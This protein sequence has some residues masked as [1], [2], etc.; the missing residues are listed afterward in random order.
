M[1]AVSVIVP[2]FKGSRFISETI[3]SI[4]NQTVAPLE[5]IIV[6]DC[7]PDPMQYFDALESSI[8]KVIRTKTNGGVCAARNV[9]INYSNGSIIAFSD[10]DDVWHPTKL[11]RQLDLFRAHPSIDFVF[12]NFDY[13]FGEERSTL[14]KFSEAPEGYWRRIAV[15]T[16]DDWIELNHPAILQFLEFQPV[17]PSTVAIRRDLIKRAGFFD[18]NLGREASEDLE[19]LFRCDAV[20][21]MAA[22]HIPLVSIRKHS[23]NYS[24]NFIATLHSQI[25]ILRRMSLLDQYSRFHYNISREIGIRSR[26]LFDAAFSDGCLHIC[27]EIEPFV[28]KALRTLKFNAKHAIINLPE[29]ARAILNRIISSRP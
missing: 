22:I 16:T 24:G 20:C 29:P 23:D 9:G 13:I 10:Q 26:T 4:L 18:E 3:Y 27:K 19:F 1:R 28:P 15:E 17:F 21:R 12:T 25:R 7:S 8:I 2:F 14:E 11:E 6:D 5:I